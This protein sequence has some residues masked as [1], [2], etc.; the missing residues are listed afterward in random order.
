M[1]YQ[2]LG[3]LILWSWCMLSIYVWQDPALPSM[4]QHMFAL[5]FTDICVAMGGFRE[6]VVVHDIGSANL[7]RKPNF[8][9]WWSWLTSRFTVSHCNCEQNWKECIRSERGAKYDNDYRHNAWF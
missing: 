8:M 7:G 3:A 1:N 4:A 2:V 6:W 5:I 9:W